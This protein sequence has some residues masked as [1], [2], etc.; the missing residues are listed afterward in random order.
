MC[1]QNSNADSNFCYQKQNI[2][3]DYEIPVQYIPKEVVRMTQRTQHDDRYTTMTWSMFLYL[4]FF[5]CFFYKAGAC[6]LVLNI[7]PLEQSL[8]KLADMFG[9]ISSNK[10]NITVFIAMLKGLRFTFDHEELVSNQG[11]TDW[12]YG[13]TVIVR[14]VLLSDFPGSSNASFPVS[15]SGQELDVRS[16][17][18][19]HQRRAGCCCWRNIWLLLQA[20]A[21]PSFTSDSRYGSHSRRCFDQMEVCVC[22]EILI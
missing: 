6:W 14:Y 16:L 5:V 1:V 10:D 19:L 2:P 17:L 3:S 22:A 9:A 11:Q 4:F 21:V 12:F 8:R 7:Y 18:W 13:D 15:L 20:A